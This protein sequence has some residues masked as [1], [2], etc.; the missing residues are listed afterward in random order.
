V[1]R[2]FGP[3][4]KQQSKFRE[5]NARFT[6]TG[7]GMRMQDKFMDRQRNLLFLNLGDILFLKHSQFTKKSGTSVH[8]GSLV[9]TAADLRES[10]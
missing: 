10:I 9:T 1:Q 8:S 2:Q 6:S 4:L 5:L 3:G 7:T